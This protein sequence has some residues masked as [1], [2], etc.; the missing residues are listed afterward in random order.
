MVTTAAKA[1]DLCSI[2]TAFDAASHVDQVGWLTATHLQL[3]YLRTPLATANLARRKIGTPFGDGAS[4]SCKHPLSKLKILS[5]IFLQMFHMHFCTTDP[6]KNRNYHTNG[7]GELNILRNKVLH[8]REHEAKRE[9]GG[10]GY[11]TSTRVWWIPRNP[12]TPLNL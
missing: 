2:L 6:Q 4:A 5:A 8:Y 3:F 9:H 12:A 7:F 1:R 11:E 10:I